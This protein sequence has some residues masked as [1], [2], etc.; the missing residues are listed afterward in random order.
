MYQVSCYL[1]ASQSALPESEA[2]QWSEGASAF[3]WE[4]KHS[5]G[6]GCA[7]APPGTSLIDRFQSI[8]SPLSPSPL[9]LTEPVAVSNTQWREQSSFKW[10][11]CG[12]RVWEY[13]DTCRLL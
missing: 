6:S 8:L 10:L 4:D 3:G 1:K 12:L 2:A 7:A 5:G 9:P 13:V 11:S